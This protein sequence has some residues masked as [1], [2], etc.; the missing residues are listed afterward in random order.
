MRQ[1]PPQFFSQELD[2]AELQDTEF[3]QFA[4]QSFDVTENLRDVSVCDCRPGARDGQDC[5]AKAEWDA[6]WH[7]C[8]LEVEAVEDWSDRAIAINALLADL[9]V[10][11]PDDPEGAA[12]AR[13]QL[14]SDTKAYETGRKRWL[15][16]TLRKR[17]HR[18]TA[19]P[20]PV[21]CRHRR[22]TLVMLSGGIDSVYTLWDSLA[23]SDDEVLAHHVHLVNLE[24]RDV[25]EARACREVVGWL[26]EHCRDF[27]YC[28]STVNRAQLSFF[29]YDMVTIGF[30]AGLAAQSFRYENNYPVDCWR[31]G[32]CQEE[33]GWAARWAHAERA[34]EAASFPFEPPGYLDVPAIPK[35]MQVEA[36]PADLSRLTWGCRQPLWDNACPLP[37]GS[38]PTCAERA[39]LGLP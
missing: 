34:C 1:L 22:V 24:D 10:A 15:I 27:R 23:N 36:M 12:M 16:W 30:E 17:E 28:E 25:P 39:K 3:A 32:S 29:G 8:G 4:L 6:L 11:A 26:R 33:G 20:Q 9:T 5:P 19:R 2:A 13:S 35:R 21:R 18:T 14:S 7:G 37:C 31:V 38:C